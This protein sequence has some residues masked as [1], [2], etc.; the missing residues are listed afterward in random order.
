LKEREQEDVKLALYC[1]GGFALR[2]QDG[3]ETVATSVETVKAIDTGKEK[4]YIRTDW[5]PTSH[6]E[7][8]HCPPHSQILGRAVHY[9]SQGDYH[10]NIL[11]PC[12]EL[13]GTEAC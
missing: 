13:K 7:M 1:N 5:D 4:R 11:W 10:E 9:C 12:I 6:W 2:K 3:F 8:L